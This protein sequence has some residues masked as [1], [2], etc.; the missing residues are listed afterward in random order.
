M[1]QLPPGTIFFSTGDADTDEKVETREKL[2]YFGAVG[3]EVTPNYIEIS[4]F[5]VLIR[6]H[7]I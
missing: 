1:A 2:I 4:Y 3:I 6:F 7:W 5:L